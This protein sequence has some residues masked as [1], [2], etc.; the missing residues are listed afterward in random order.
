MTY[1]LALKVD[2]GLVLVS[3]SRTNAGVD[4]INTYRKMRVFDQAADR[5]LVLLSAG[6]LATT[7]A[8]ANRLQRDLGD[9]RAK[10]NLHNLDYMF[11]AAEYVGQISR[12]AQSMTGPGQGSVNTSASFILGGQIKGQPPR[13]YLIYPEGN[14]IQ[15]SASAPY[16][17]I[18]ETK[19]GKP[20]LDRV[21]QSSLS[22][23]AAARLAL[24]S[25]DSTRRSNVSVGPPFEVTYY[26]NDSLTVTRQLSLDRDDPQF[27]QVC[28]AWEK[29]L[30][31]GF[32]SLPAFSWE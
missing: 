24:V 12:R 16:L 1:C 15:A 29:A 32:A 22:L 21:L 18:G 20:I 14:Y 19:Y 27:V 3:D 13:L 30:I 5:T 2:A 4:H 8:V 28:E 10:V 25:M 7:Q 6:N 17:Q 26:R 11:D 9:S 31:D 23:D